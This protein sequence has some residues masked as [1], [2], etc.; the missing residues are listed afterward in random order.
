MCLICDRIEM[1]KNGANPYFVRELETGYVV[2]GDKQYFPG[3]VLFLCKYHETELFYL[4]DDIR[5]LF[6][7]EMTIVAEA[8]SIAFKADKINYEL[9]GNGDSHVHWHIFTRKNGDLDEYGVNGVGPVWWAPWSIM[10]DE[11]YKV[12]G[13]TLEKMKSDL[14]AALDEALRKRNMI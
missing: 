10:N 6:L 1:I 12:K 7:D 9:L 14:S 13:D 3:Y 2:I 5:R 8:V 11:K 4:D